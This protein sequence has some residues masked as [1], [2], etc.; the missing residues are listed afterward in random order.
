MRL[1]AVG[2]ISCRRRPVR[3]SVIR[4]LPN[5]VA[6][7]AQ[8]VQFAVEQTLL[9]LVVRDDFADFPGERPGQ[10]RLVA[11]HVTDDGL[12]AHP[13]PLLFLLHGHD[14]LLQVGVAV[15]RLR[16]QILQHVTALLQPRILQ[17]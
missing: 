10:R 3:T 6:V 13:Q 2:M 11:S 12:G 5:S 9:F 4:Q 14:A 15:V 16:H 7:L 17:L 8:S 1:G